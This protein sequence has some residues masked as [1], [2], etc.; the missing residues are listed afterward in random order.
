VPRRR[1][2]QT[3]PRK[4]QVSEW[5]RAWAT[6]ALC[7]DGL[8][9]VA[10]PARTAP[11]VHC[12]NRQTAQPSLAATPLRDTVALLRNELKKVTSWQKQQHNGKRQAYRKRRGVANHGNGEWRINTWVSSTA[13]LALQRLACRDSV[14]M[15][16][17]LER[18]ILDEDGEILARL[19]PDTPEWDRY[20]RKV[21]VTQ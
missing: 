3:Q 1:P 2:P 13:H 15:C 11:I 20:I 7:A 8:L 6:S 9:A 21:R 12:G 18:L 5:N 16:D 4:T 19:E 17:M 10:P 14:T